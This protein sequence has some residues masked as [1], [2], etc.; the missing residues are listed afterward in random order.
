MTTTLF[1]SCVLASCLPTYDARYGCTISS[2]CWGT[3]GEKKCAK[4]EAEPLPNIKPVWTTPV[5]HYNAMVSVQTRGYGSAQKILA[6][7]AR[8]TALPGWHH[9]HPHVALPAH[10]LRAKLTGSGWRARCVRGVMSVRRGDKYNIYK[11][12]CIHYTVSY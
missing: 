4:N 2:W 9:R 6:R 12:R 5:Y 8:D 7:V 1:V 3:T 11:V 10:W